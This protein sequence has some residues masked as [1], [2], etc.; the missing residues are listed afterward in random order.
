[1]FI[2][3]YIYRRYHQ[4]QNCQNH[5]TKPRNLSESSFWKRVSKLLITLPRKLIAKLASKSINSIKTVQWIV[6]IEL[7]KDLIE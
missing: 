2:T 3:F 4:S 1:M 6:S 5:W 7:M